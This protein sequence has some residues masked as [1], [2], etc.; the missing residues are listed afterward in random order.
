[1]SLSCEESLGKEDENMGRYAW[2]ALIWTV[3]GIVASYLMTPQNSCSVPVNQG[4]SF[5]GVLWIT[6]LGGLLMLD[7]L[8]WSD[9]DGSNRTNRKAS[10][11]E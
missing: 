3:F 1:L 10:G 7:I 2:T 6:I 9:K 11:L 8:D 4:A 5:F